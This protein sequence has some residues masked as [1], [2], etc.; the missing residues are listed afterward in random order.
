MQG[1]KRQLIFGLIGLGCGIV[2]SGILNLLLLLNT[3][4][5]KNGI[6]LNVSQKAQSTLETESEETEHN[7]L[8]DVQ[9][10]KDEVLQNENA[11]EGSVQQSLVTET[12]ITADELEKESVTVT[13]PPKM[14]ASQTC[15]LLEAAGVINDAK[16]FKNYISEKRMTTKLN[17]GTFVLSKN[18]EYNEILD[19]LMVD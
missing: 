18:M 12:E 1:K 8:N 19:K 2:L 7:R 4:E 3:T 6:T 17:E 14:T 9:A 15:D 11:A 10:A 5:Y 16:D 13:I